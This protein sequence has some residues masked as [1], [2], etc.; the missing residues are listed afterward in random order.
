MIVVHKTLVLAESYLPR[1]GTNSTWRLHISKFVKVR[2]QLRFLQF[3]HDAWAIP[4]ILEVL[5]NFM[6][7]YFA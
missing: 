3:L 7:G 2:I 6:V 4:M 1:Q 5:L